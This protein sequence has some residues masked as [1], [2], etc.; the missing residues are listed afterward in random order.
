MSH[1]D[2]PEKNLLADIK[3]IERVNRQ[4]FTS[5][6][7]EM[8]LEDE[9]LWEAAGKALLRLRA[10]KENMSLAPKEISAMDG[11]LCN[12]IYVHFFISLIQLF[13]DY[14]SLPPKEKTT[15]GAKYREKMEKMAGDAKR[16]GIPDA[17]I[18]LYNQ[19]A[20]KLGLFKESA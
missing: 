5:I 12:I 6:D 17:H 8:L 16:Y 14:Q 15:Q 1:A 9:M 4:E 19:I 7:I 13:H 2:P 11:R 18:A 20:K 10:K 3:R